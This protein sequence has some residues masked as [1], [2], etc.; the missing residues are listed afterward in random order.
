LLWNHAA[1]D[2]T[3]AHDPLFSTLGDRFFA[4]GDERGSLEFPP[5]FGYYMAPASANNYWAMQLM[6]HNLSSQ[7]QTFRLKMIFT[8]HPASDNLRNMRHLWLDAQNCLLT[9]SSFPIPAGYTDDHWDWTV[10]AGVEGKVMMMGGHVHDWGTSVAATK[11]TAANSPLICA[12]RGSYAPGS[13]YAPATI[14]SP[15][16]PA[17]AH[18]AS[19]L[20]ANPSDPDYG[21]HIEAMEACTPDTVIAPGD[22]IR[23]HTQY[24]TPADIPDV[25]GIMG[26]WLYDNCPSSNPDQ[27]DFDGDY[28]GD[29]C[30]PDID[31]DSIANGS[32]SEADGDGLANTLESACGSNPLHSGSTPE[33]TDPGL[34]GV[35]D[36]RDGSTDEALPGGAGASDCDRD[37]FD[38]TSEN[39]IFAGTG[40]RDQDA[41]GNNGWPIDLVG[42]EISANKVTLGDIGSYFAPVN[43]FNTNTG[44]SPGDHRWDVAP[45]SVSGPHINLQDIGSLLAGQTAAPPMLGVTAF[46]GPTCPW[47]P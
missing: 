45:G 10:T 22:T 30:D 46:N 33:R 5:G 17:A 6:I 1:L 25:M 28:A 35:D 8:Y 41:C 7:Q 4:A 47:P 9:G 15:P 32:D 24:N 44:T 16:A 21:G 42:G 31:G 34:A 12:S 43:Y 11:G 2:T 18:P 20:V 14:P 40:G 26:T 36:D 39:A 29:P 27:T 23:L 19:A 37:G 38:G 13:P 3:C